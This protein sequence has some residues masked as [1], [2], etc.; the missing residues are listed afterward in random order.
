MSLDTVIQIRSIQPL[1][2]KIADRYVEVK[3]ASRPEV[4]EGNNPTRETAIPPTQSEPTRD[5]VEVAVSEIS[6]YVQSVHRN[7]N[8]TV[9]DESGRTVV[10]VIDTESDEVIRQIPSEEMLALATRIHDLQGDDLS[11][12]FVTSEA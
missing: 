10:K 11:G 2:Q 12:L 9:D 8:F 5:E 7:L 4:Q 6:Q 1:Q 3:G